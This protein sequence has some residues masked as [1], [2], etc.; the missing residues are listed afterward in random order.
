MQGRIISFEE[1]R[2][3]ALEILR[4][5]NKICRENNI[6]YTLFSG[7]A[8]GAIRH[9]GFI[10]WDD[11]IDIALLAPEYARLIAILSKDNRYRLLLPENGKYN[12]FFA[13]L[14]DKNSYVLQNNYHDIEELGIWVD[15]FPLNNAGDS[16]I[17]AQKFAQN[18]QKQDKK[19]VDFVGAK[20]Y[21]Q[22]SRKSYELIKL[23]LYFMPAQL[24]RAAWQRNKGKVLEFIQSKNSQ[25]TQFVSSNAVCAG[26]EVYEKDLF[27]HLVEVPFEDGSYL[28]VRDFDRLLS[29]KYGD[30]MTLPPERERVPHHLGQYLWRESVAN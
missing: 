28:I 6:Q 10:P 4:Y 11:D 2:A 20:H 3:V 14:C 25:P 12:R 15:I 1:R 21:Y 17:E 9:G 27:E 5:I 8:L 13:K 30:Y 19:F 26:C 18:C 22:A 24:Y 23:P 16:L 7:T 29:V